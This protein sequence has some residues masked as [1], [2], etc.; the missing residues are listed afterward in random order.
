MPPAR[1]PG[2]QDLNIQRRRSKELGKKQ[3]V[4]LGLR[5]IVEATNSWWSNYG[6]PRRNSDGRTRHR[7][8]AL[9]LATTILVGRLIDWRNHWNPA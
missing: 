5:W 2:L 8:A 4:R 3:P 7:H 1:R 6:Q 9:C